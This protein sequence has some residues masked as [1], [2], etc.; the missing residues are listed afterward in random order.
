MVNC[1]FWSLKG[2]FSLHS[3]K[4]LYA[5]VRAS[6]RAG[7]NCKYHVPV[8]SFFLFQLP[9]LTSYESEW[10]NAVTIRLD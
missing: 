9:H 6:G 7:L 10:N 8:W 5:G 4:F 3:L 2:L 1:C